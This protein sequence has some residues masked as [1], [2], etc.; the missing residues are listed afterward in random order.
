M[1]SSGA[2]GRFISLPPA[3][4]IWMRCV[5][6]GIVLAVLAISSGKKIWLGWGRDFKIVFAAGIFMG[7]HWIS[8]FY[9]LKFSTVAIGM[10]S[11]FTYPMITALLEPLILKVK[12]EKRHIPLAMIA[13]F[14]V[15]QLVPEFSFENEYTIGILIGVG[16]A[17][18]YAVRNILLKKNIAGISGTVMMLYQLVII[19]VFFWPFFLA[20]DVKYSGIT[21]QQNLIG[22]LALGLF[23]TAAGH[24]LFIK[25]FKFFSITTV[26]I[27]SNLTPLFGIVLGFLILSEVPDGNIILGG[28]LILSTTIVEGVVSIRSKGV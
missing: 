15:F 16:S 17:T 25:S 6:A 26:S 24:T 3:F 5:I 12:L 7:I 8:Y 20:E 18:A 23:T 14:G 27:L 4:T 2:L 11:L 10:L 9:A 22:L 13:L 19:I 1:S 21:T 28:A